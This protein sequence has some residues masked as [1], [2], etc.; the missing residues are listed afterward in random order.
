MIDGTGS[1]TSS[2]PQGLGV[3]VTSADALQTDFLRL[4]TTQ[5]ANQDPFNPMDNM[6]MVQQLATFSQLQQ[7]EG[8]NSRLDT[9]LQMN[10]SMNNTMMMGLVGKRVTVLGNEVEMQDGKP[11]RSLVRASDSGV[12]VAKIY[13]SEGELVRTVDNLALRPG[14]TTIEWDGKS[15]SG[16]SLPDGSYTMEIEAQRPGD[17][18]MLGVALFQSGLVDTIQFDNNFQ[19]I[20]VNGA[21]YSPAEIVEV[22]VPDHVTTSSGS[23]SGSSPS[24]GGKG[25]GVEPVHGTRLNPYENL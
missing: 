6:Q 13:N 17:G 15:D 12:G 8:V 9:S 22:G 21:E 25:A 19:T 18:G 23:S 3:K 16:E 4:L 14:F 11:S 10:Q 2:T 7:L 1:T 20:I 24:G 5:L